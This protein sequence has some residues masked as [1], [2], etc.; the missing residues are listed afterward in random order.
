[1]TAVTALAP[2][3][4][5]TRTRPW[6]LSVHHRDIC[7]SQGQPY[8]SSIIL[9]VAGH[10]LRAATPRRRP[11]PLSPPAPTTPKPYRRPRTARGPQETTDASFGATA[12]AF[13]CATTVRHDLRL[14]RPQHRWLPAASAAGVSSACAQD[15]APVLLSGARSVPTARFLDLVASLEDTRCAIVDRLRTTPSFVL[16]AQCSMGPRPL[17][18]P[19]P[20]LATVPIGHRHSVTCTPA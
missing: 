16:R 5:R 15:G 6:T 3:S 19:S 12:I 9:M 8:R 4:D 2:P 1:M 11:R 17:R 18:D 14:M 10:P 20:P 13:R 7:Q